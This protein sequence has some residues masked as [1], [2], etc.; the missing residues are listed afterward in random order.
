M[1]KLLMI[2]VLGLLLVGCAPT[3]YEGFHKKHSRNNLYTVKAQ[4][5]SKNGWAASSSPI[6][7][8]DAAN[9]AIKNCNNYN[10]SN[11]C[12]SHTIAGKYVFDESKQDYQ[13]QIAQNICRKVGYTE[14]T[15]K[16]ADC[17][18]KMMSRAQTQI[19]SKGGSTVIY[20]QR[21]YPKVACDAMGGL[22]C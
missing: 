1:K 19:Q 16:F 11:D 12:V 22:V 13:I 5:I 9:R 14:D 21:K 3:S 15:E 18:I 10:K 2:L 4:S 20:T 7:F 8:A 17:T 6:S